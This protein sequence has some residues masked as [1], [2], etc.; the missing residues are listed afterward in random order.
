MFSV[1]KSN[2]VVKRR[3]IVTIVQIVP[4]VG[5]EASGPT[6]SVVRLAQFLAREG[7]RVKL[8]SVLDG[9]VA[10]E[11]RFVHHVYARSRVLERLWRSPMLAEALDRAAEEADVVHS[12]GMWVMPAVYPGESARRFRIPLVISP[13]GCLSPVALRRSG[14]NKRAFWRLYHKRTFQYC[15]CIHATSE[16]EYADIRAF[17][18]DTPV[19]IVPNGVEGPL[20]ASRRQ[21]E[22][23][24]RSRRVL[25]LGRIHPIKGI[26]VL[27]AAWK[28]I[29][30]SAFSE[31]TLRVVGQDEDGYLSR[32]RD[33]VAAQ[34]IPSVEF[35]G[36][37]YS[38]AKWQEYSSAALYVLPSHSENFG[39]TIA[40]SLAAGIPVIATRGTPWSELP[41]R[42]CGWWTE[43]SVAALATALREALQLRDRERQDMGR[44]GSEWMRE[45]FDWRLVARRM[46]D[47]YGWSMEGG[48]PPAC[49]RMS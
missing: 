46:C 2:G 39:M 37:K 25:Y 43:L 30:A 38:D 35:V 9:Q 10:H 42:G 7:Q 22:P 20:S 16:K 12:H 28:E 15:R 24:K 21:F 29:K 27:L 45:S 14:W 44:L 41:R 36:P 34:R 19:A 26:D 17:G 31:W 3:I 33:M 4:H 5:N 8:L 47:V 48:T 13:R 6:Y 40:E 32:L 49:V 18:L 23:I 1:A 11:A